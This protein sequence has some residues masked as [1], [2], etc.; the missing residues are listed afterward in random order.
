[1]SSPPGVGSGGGAVKDIILVLGQ[2]ASCCLSWHPQLQAGPSG[3]RRRSHSPI[4]G[5]KI[6]PRL[7]LP[8]YLWDC[9]RVQIDPL[10]CSGLPQLDLIHK[11][12]LDAGQ[13]ILL[14]VASTRT[15]SWKHS[16]KYRSNIQAHPNT[17]TWGEDRFQLGSFSPRWRS[18]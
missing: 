7:S 12:H 4:W 17:E 16:E 10:S 6:T 11:V 13:W 2:A 1:M 18:E 3:G 9:L 15:P 5:P 8:E 14:Q